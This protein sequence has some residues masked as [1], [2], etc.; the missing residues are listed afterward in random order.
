MLL[1][2]IVLG[3]VGLLADI[4]YKRTLL[5]VTIAGFL[6]FTFFALVGLMPTA[7][8]FWY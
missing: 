7:R 8:F 2:I 4:N 1:S 5:G 6:L 3:L